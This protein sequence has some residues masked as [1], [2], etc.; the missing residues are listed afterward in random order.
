MSSTEAFSFKNIKN[1]DD[2]IAQSI[3]N[4]DLLVE[5]ILSVAP[6]F[7]TPDAGIIDLGCSTGKL[8]EAIPYS[9]HKIGYDISQN[10]LPVSNENTNFVLQDITTVDEFNNA[11]L[12]LSIFTMQFIQKSERQSLLSKIHDCLIDGGAFIWAEKV[13]ADSSF[14]EHIFTSAHHDF[15]R[16]S[17]SAQEISDKDQDLRS[18]MRP[19]NSLENNEMAWTAGFRKQALMWKFFNFECFVYVKTS[20]TCP[21]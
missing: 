9:G 5:S 18:M 15:K 3:P 21:Y 1:F 20:P 11:S 8:I 6:Y 13:Y 19:Q 4:Y 12:V 14:W 10:L 2:H 7:L 16:K 17:F